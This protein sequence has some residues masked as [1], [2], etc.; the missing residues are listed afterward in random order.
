MDRTH[1][2]FFTWH[3]ADR[4]LVDTVK[5]LKLVDKVADGSAPLWVLRRWLLPVALSKKIDAYFVRLFP[6]LFGQQVVM[7]VSRIEEHYGLQPP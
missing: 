4:Y 3:T 2:H 6:N 7:S 5:E 1:L